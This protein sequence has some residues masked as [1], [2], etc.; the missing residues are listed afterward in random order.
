M[1]II[2]QN[3]N[4]NLFVAGNH[5]NTDQSAA[6]RFS[7]GVEA[8]DFCRYKELENMDIVLFFG[9]ASYDIRVRVPKRLYRTA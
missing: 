3:R 7:S 8:F 4:T 5:W 1:S 2:L 6:T 9:K